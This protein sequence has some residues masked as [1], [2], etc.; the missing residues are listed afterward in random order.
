MVNSKQFVKNLSKVTFIL[1]C[2]V[3]LISCLEQGEDGTN[4]QNITGI[5]EQRES[6]AVN[7]A[8]SFQQYSALLT[9][10]LMEA[11]QAQN[12]Q[13]HDVWQNGTLDGVDETGLID[14]AVFANMSNGRINE[15]V[16]AAYCN[17]VIFS[18]FKG[19]ASG[20]TAGLKGLGDGGYQS[21]SKVLSRQ[22]G[23]SGFGIYD[24]E[25]IA[26]K[27]GTHFYPNCEAASRMPKGTPVIFTTVS[28]MDLSQSGTYYEFYNENCPDGSEGF[29]RYRQ[30]VSVEY[31]NDGNEISRSEGDPQVFLNSCR[32]A[33][34]TVNVEL[35]NM[36]TVQT[37]D[38]SSQSGSGQ[39]LGATKEVIC[40]EADVKNSDSSSASDGS[41]ADQITNCRPVGG[42]ESSIGDG[43]EIDCGSHIAPSSTESQVMACQGNGWTGDVDYEREVEYC[44]VNGGP[45]DGMTFE[46]KGKWERVAID[47]SRNE[48]QS[49][50]CPYGSG[51][52][53]YNRVNRIVDVNTL[54]PTNPDW[55]YTSDSCNT[56]ET[57]SCIGA[58]AGGGV[59]FAG[60]SNGANTPPVAQTTNMANYCGSGSIC[61]R[62]RVLSCPPNRLGNKVQQ[63]HYLC[64]S[65]WT[66]W[67]DTDPNA[68]CQSSVNFGSGDINFTG[69][70][71][72][73]WN[74]RITCDHCNGGTDGIR[75]THYNAGLSPSYASY[76][77]GSIN[78]GRCKTSSTSGTFRSNGNGFTVYL[79]ACANSLGN[80]ISFSHRTRFH[81]SGDYS[82][83]VYHGSGTCEAPP[84][85]SCSYNGADYTPGESVTR[86]VG[87]ASG[88]SGDRVQEKSC[89]NNGTWTSWSDQTNTCTANTCS[90]GG[91]TYNVG[92]T[93]TRNPS[94]PSGESGTITE[95][96]TC[97][98]NGNLSSWSETS[99]TC[100]PN[101]ACTRGGNSYYVG[102]KVTETANCEDLRPGYV[103]TVTVE[104]EC[105]GGGVWD[106]GWT[107]IVSGSCTRTCDYRGTTYLEGDKITRYPSCPSGETGSITEEA[108]CQSD[109][110]VSSF[111]ETAN[112]CADDCP[113]VTVC[114]LGSQQNIGRVTGTTMI[115]EEQNNYIGHCA[116]LSETLENRTDKRNYIQEWYD[117]GRGGSNGPG[118]ISG[119]TIIGGN[120]GD[121]CI[122]D[123]V[124]G[125]SNGSAGSDKWRRFVRDITSCTTREPAYCNPNAGTG[126]GGSGSGGSGGSGSGGGDTSINPGGGVQIRAN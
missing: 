73:D 121:T 17:G 91:S 118:N 93:V 25:A 51:L 83:R 27:N 79:R 20:E 29:I 78:P 95:E 8:R 124:L 77:F 66:G 61:T 54:A 107:R 16:Q 81:D 59:A 110:T 92:D 4:Q 14:T 1:L 104:Y 21:I 41:G 44:R 12:S 80:Q 115:T 52:V 74:H 15:H 18:W 40:F 105:T 49:V 72:T 63:R 97:Q 108:T 106:G 117:R 22:L 60:T 100:S 88:E 68:C 75:S 37:V 19:S 96:A 26:S 3:F 10:N 28:N 24:G 6:T 57:S 87:C 111:T 39:N 11:A 98:S 71:G 50:S 99:N 114:A 62:Q 30:M 126:S 47:C 33:I 112:S 48:S 116:N 31:D 85:N 42:F 82:N 89:Q 120:V 2:C 35:T 67:S 64:G 36:P 76:Y 69:P 32:D 34:Q 9:Q 125:D 58:Y 65:G 13:L 84:E 53:F 23:A 46:R 122:D 45:D 109:G 94:C 101:P 43:A 70:G 102:D 119:N 38:F 86:N 7:Y 56:D 55:N 123:L 5:M 113:E 103:G 90:Y